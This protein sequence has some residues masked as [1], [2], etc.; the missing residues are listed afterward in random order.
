M[1]LTETQTVKASGSAVLLAGSG[2]IR[3]KLW[4]LY[5][6]HGQTVNKSQAPGRTVGP[7]YWGSSEKNLAVRHLSGAYN[8]EVAHTF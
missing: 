7:N 6:T 1:Q 2:G 5:E 8:F 3:K 4:W